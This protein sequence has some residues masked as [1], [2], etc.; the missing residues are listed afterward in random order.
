MLALPDAQA[1]T[2]CPRQALGATHDRQR[3][4][5]KSSIHE[6]Y[7]SNFPQNTAAVSFTLDSNGGLLPSAIYTSPQTAAMACLS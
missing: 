4:Q 7:A 2:P 5:L 3:G 6:Q 1:L